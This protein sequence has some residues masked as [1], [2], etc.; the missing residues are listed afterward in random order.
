MKKADKN[1]IFLQD[2]N[3]SNNYA[4]RLIAEDKAVQ[5]T[6][7]LAYHQSEG[8]GHA[9]NVW[10]SEANKNLLVSFIFFPAFLPAG[11]QFYLSK[12]TSLAIIDLLHTASVFAAIKWPNDIYVGNKKIAGILIENS[13]S[14]NQLHS[15]VVGIGL[16]LNQMHFGEK[17]PNPV[18][19]KQ[20]IQKD[21][22]IE[23]MAEKL[24]ENLFSWYHELEKGKT[25]EI[26][27]AY[28]EKLYRLNEW[29]LFKIGAKTF[30]ARIQ[31]V[32]EYGQLILQDRQGHEKEYQFK[33]IEFVI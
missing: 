32:G 26:D 15:S 14:G 21:Y 27:S 28:F 4:K 16:N 9:G 19:L 3:S 20:L 22:L 12:I 30:E 1:T 11:A 23:K 7:V 18:S 31:G 2:V 33:E 17:V 6:V 10:E 13:V 8:K 25:I 29:A 5:G 24:K